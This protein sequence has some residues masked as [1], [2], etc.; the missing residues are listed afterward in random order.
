MSAPGR[1]PNPPPARP[2]LQGPSHAWIPWTLAGLVAAGA[3]L[4]GAAGERVLSA[5]SFTLLAAFGAFLAWREPP[6]GAEGRVLALAALVSVPLVAAAAL[7]AARVA[8]GLLILAVG[9]A[10]QPIVRRAL[11]GA[12]GAVW[13]R[14]G[15]SFA[16]LVA[17]LARPPRVEGSTWVVLGAVLVLQSSWLVLLLRARREERDP[18]RPFRCACPR[19]GL[20]RSRA[21]GK[22]P[23]AGCGLFLLL[24]RAPAGVPPE[25]PH[26]TPAKPIWSLCPTCRLRLFAPRGRSVCPQCRSE[27]WAEWNEHVIGGAVP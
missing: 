13:G 3:W 20:I 22:A 27:L 2:A 18:A 19:C 16:L 11:G 14:G 8:P 6:V 12:P 4:G 23:C 10:H 25:P 7:G 24:D 1:D 9:A 5:G 26:P 17:L 21:P 15:F